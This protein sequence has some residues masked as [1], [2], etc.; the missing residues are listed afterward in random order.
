MKLTNDSIAQAVEDIQ[1]FFAQ[2]DVSER[3]RTKINLITVNS[4][5]FFGMLV[6]NCEF[7]DLSHSVKFFDKP[8]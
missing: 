7:Y 6:H 4:I 3:D 8:V 2:A 1:R 5:S